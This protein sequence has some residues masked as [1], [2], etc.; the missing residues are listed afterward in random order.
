MKKFLM[1]FIG[2]MLLLSVVCAPAMAEFIDQDNDGIPDAVESAWGLDPANP[3]DRWNIAP[4]GL[5]YVSNYVLDLDPS[6]EPTLVVK[7][8]AADNPNADT[9]DIEAAVEQAMRAGGPALVK[10]QGGE[11]QMEYEHKNYSSV[12]PKVMFSG[13][14]ND[15]F[16]VQSAETQTVLFRT[17][18]NRI[19][20]YA[21]N[22]RPSSESFVFEWLRF[23]GGSN[24]DDYGFLV[25]I[26]KVSDDTLE[27]PIKLMFS[28]C[29]FTNQV[30]MDEYDHY[31]KTYSGNIL[32]YGVKWLLVSDTLNRGCRYGVGLSVN[33]LKPKDG[34]YQIANSTFVA[35]A[36]NIFF[37]VPAH[38]Q[39]INSIEWPWGSRFHIN[40]TVAFKDLVSLGFAYCGSRT[41]L[42]SAQESTQENVISADPM[43][44][45]TTG[46]LLPGSPAIGVGSLDTAS[47]VDLLGKPRVKNDIGAMQRTFSAADQP[48]VATGVVQKSPQTAIQGGIIPAA[49]KTAAV[50]MKLKKLAPSLVGKPGGVQ[51][52]FVNQDTGKTYYVDLVNKK[53]VS[54][55]LIRAFNLNLTTWDLT[56]YLPGMYK[57][58]YAVHLKGFKKV[59][60]KMKQIDRKSVV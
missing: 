23:E 42:K 27:N 25:D 58:N 49:M 2:L 29:T 48:M 24:K 50:K 30:P 56:R 18:Y 5:S 59:N 31:V 35:N 34:Y 45:M 52:Y 38:L 41:S 32:L 11:Y 16:T 17:K 43:I 8:G 13:S 40:G 20:Y 39:I 4:N 55:P 19:F 14:W 51:I 22:D 47:P 33:N 1:I 3:K 60:G 37:Y 6:Q 26:R 12:G 36:L 21:I 9:S 44:D 10:I 53:L 15:T 7:V 57:G 46:L 54:K 28:W